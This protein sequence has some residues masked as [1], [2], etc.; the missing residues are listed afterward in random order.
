[1]IYLFGNLFAILAM[2]TGF[3]MTGLA[4]KDSLVWDYK[5][6]N[7]KSFLITVVI[8]LIIFSLGVRQFIAVIDIVGGV[9]V[10]SQ[11]L[12]ALL[13]YWRA[14]TMGHLKNGKYQLHH[15]LLTMIPL[16]LILLIGT[17]YSV[18]KLFF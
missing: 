14:K 5:I 13:I 15:I 1:M 2:G 16:F 8:P 10:S 17:I 12:L 7:I 4:L 6:S 3:L 11:M 9:V 18:V